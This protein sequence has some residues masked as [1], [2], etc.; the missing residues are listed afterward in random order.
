M[1]ECMLEIRQQ[2]QSRDKLSAGYGGDTYNTAYALAQSSIAV[3]Y[4]TALGADPRSDELVRQWEQDGVDT[5]AVQ[6]LP[7]RQPGLYWISTDMAGERQF[8]Y[9]RQASAAT[10]LL[11]TPRDTLLQACAG[12]SHVYLSLITAA[13]VADRSGLLDLLRALS[14]DC[15]IVYD[16]NFR[17]QLWKSTTE[18]LSWHEQLLAL[19]DIYLP[20]LDDEMALY[21]RPADR[22]LDSLLAHHPQRELV[23]RCGGQGARLP[24]E[25]A[26][27]QTI[28][29]CEVPV[30]D[31]TG[32]GDAF[33]GGYLAARLHGQNPTQAARHAC[34]LAGAVVGHSGALLPRQHP[35]FS[36]HNQD[37][38]Q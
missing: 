17:P 5:S 29:A 20:S 9:W 37:R 2:T 14:T 28:P 7:G 23:V 27:W 34:A 35:S 8:Q 24:T 6:R 22:A 32:A 4:L 30:V 3:S 15:S 38:I 25:S 1:G 19:S 31:S 16:S 11:D 26:D 33:N 13:I 18:A 12:A 10:R 36:L 21:Q